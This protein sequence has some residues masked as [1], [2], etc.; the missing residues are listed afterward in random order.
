[1]GP[2]EETM[3]NKIILLAGIYAFILSSLFAGNLRAEEPDV[4]A[5]VKFL[6]TNVTPDGMPLSYQVP[7]NYW[8]DIK[9]PQDS[10]DA[11]IER[12][13]AT[14]SLSVYDGALWQIVQAL[15][16]NIKEATAHTER[17]ISAQSGDLQNIR[18]NNGFTYAG[19][20]LGV[21]E[22]YFF[23]LISD[24]YLQSDPLDGKTRLEGF[25]NWADLH[26]EDWVPVTGENSWAAIIG[27]LQ[28]AFVRYSGQIPLDSDE[29]KLATSIIPAVELLQSPIGGIYYAPEGT[30]GVKPNFISTENNIS[31][32]AALRMLK[33]AIGDRDPAMTQ[34]LE[35]LI[36]GIE[37]FLRDYA[38]DK[39]NRLFYQGGHNEGRQ[40][41]ATDLFAVDC[42]TW[43]LAILGAKWIDENFGEGIAYGLWQTTKSRAGYYDSMDLENVRGVGYTDGHDIL[44]GEWSFGA[45]LAIKE[46]AN[47]YQETKPE[48]TQRL[49]K[50]IF[51]IKESV[52]HLRQVGDNGG[53]SYKYSNKR[54]YI[55]FGWW[56]NPIPSVSS[57]AWAYFNKTDFNP[58]LL[59]GGQNSHPERIDKT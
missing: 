39:A 56:A 40:F 10:V 28:V 4:E 23:R 53:V 55:P 16:G 7:K 18:A 9:H 11:V 25:P 50:D 42:Q 20:I 48:W 32:L 13:L 26:H 17:L 15:A 24:R 57:T 3:K 35:A 29:M 52:E 38:F 58:F 44:S 51:L 49:K 46:T 27:P 12:L 8:K 45:L 31:M 21:D 14:H 59:G 5:L 22:A 2:A 33:E 37:K 19:K 6:S 41:V 36:S 30:Y 1:M 54:F 43:G 47:Y 34:R